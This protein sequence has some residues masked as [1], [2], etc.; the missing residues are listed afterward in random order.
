MAHKQHRAAFAFADVLHF[1]DG[2]FLEFGVADGEDFIDNQYLGVEVGGD[3]EAEAHHH[4]AG[5]ALHRGVDITFAAAEVDDFVQLLA[6]F[7]FR[8]AQ[9]GAVHVDVL[10]ACHLGVEAGADLEQRPDASTGTDGAGG[11]GGNFGEDLQQGALAGTVL[12]DDAYHVALL[13]FEVDVLQGPHVVAGTFAAA[14]VGLAYGEV[15]V[16]LAPYVHGPPALEVVRQGAGAHQ[17]Q[18]VDLAD[19]VE[20]Y[21][22]RHVCYIL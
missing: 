17:A 10:A 19:V 15:G 20:F 4:A 8:H 14:V 18:A 6:D 7:M 22:G 9:D 5:V 13:D 21:S 3:G 1:S 2:F 16:F 12:A 11:G